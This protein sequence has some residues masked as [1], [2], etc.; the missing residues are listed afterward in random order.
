MKINEYARPE[1]LATLSVIFII[2]HQIVAPINTI[3]TTTE[4]KFFFLFT[5]PK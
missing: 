2:C 1:A 4:G 3:V 5:I